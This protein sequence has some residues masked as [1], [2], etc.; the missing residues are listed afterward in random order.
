MRI[1]VFHVHP[2]AFLGYLLHCGFTFGN[3]F[4]VRFARL[5]ATNDAFGRLGSFGLGEDII[6]Q[7]GVNLAGILGC[8][9]FPQ[10][11]DSLLRRLFFHPLPR[12]WLLRLRA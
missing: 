3:G 1:S 2:P 8:E 11:I 7:D 4:I 12:F 5:L 10:L 6:R 9:G